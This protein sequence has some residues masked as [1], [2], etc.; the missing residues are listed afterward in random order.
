[1]EKYHFEMNER[2]T[3][4]WKFSRDAM[5]FTAIKTTVKEI[6][7]TGVW[8]Q[9]DGEEDESFVAYPDM[10]LFIREGSTTPEG[11]QALSV[12]Q[13]TEAHFGK[14]DPEMMIKLIESLAE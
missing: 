13:I 10:H 6:E 8:F 4:F 11:T 9:F 3:F 2:V 1:M 12:N 14:V 5:N 7:D